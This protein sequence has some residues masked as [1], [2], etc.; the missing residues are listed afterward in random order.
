MI[1]KN[2][3]P[4]CGQLYDTELAR[5]PLCGTAPQVVDTDAPVQRRR[6]TEAERRQRRAERTEAEQ[7]ARRRRKDEQL[8]RDAEEERLL[9]EEREAR[10][11]EKRRKKEEKRTMKEDRPAPAR[12]VSPDTAPVPVV[13]PTPAQGKEAR[14][15][16]KKEPQR[17][18]GRVPR[19]YLVISCVA[20]ALALIIGSTYLLWKTELAKIPF[21][22][23]LKGSSAATEPAPTDTEA[24]TTEDTSV[25]A[26]KLSLSKTELTFTQAG[27]S[28]QLRAAVEPEDCTDPVQFT[29]SD[30]TVAKVGATGMVTAAGKGTATITA[31]CGEAVAQCVVTVDIPET[32]EPSTE[33]TSVEGGLK[34]KVDDITFFE[35][36]ESTV[37]IV[38]NVPAGTTVT[39]SSADESIATVDAEGHVTAVG[40][41]TTTVTATV[42][43]QSAQC[44]VRCN[45][46]EE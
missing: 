18:R 28:E 41:G 42:G 12:P 8:A 29:S 38:E 32:T 22:D 15:M 27:D 36:K 3:C 35:A 26:T 37:L 5:C 1:N 4:N 9:E 24:P 31:Q 46:R 25:R 17:D 20:L 14:P 33:S 45:F 43:E 30:D 10:R 34:L 16:P 7:E 44:V 19:A 11:A 23:N 40:K 21:Y 2:V 39:W 6:I 13:T